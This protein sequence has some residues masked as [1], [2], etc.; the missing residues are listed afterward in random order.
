MDSQIAGGF[1]SYREP[2]S[3]ELA[4]VNKLKSAIEQ[5]VNKKFLFFVPVKIKSQV[6][7]GTNYTVKI[8]VNNDSFI[9][10]TIFKPLPYTGESPSVSSVVEGK[11]QDDGL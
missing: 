3:E 9:H 2:T 1:S 6:V 4:M 11:R 8:L 7:A 5:K 10:V